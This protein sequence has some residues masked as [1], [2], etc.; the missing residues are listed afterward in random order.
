MDFNK[1]VLQGLAENPKYL[2]D[3]F[4]RESLKAIEN[5]YTKNEFFE[6]SK[7]V[8]NY[9]SQKLD[10][11]YFKDLDKLNDA[12]LAFDNGTFLVEN[13]K[14]KTKDWLNQYKNQIEEKRFST[15]T[16]LYF[17]F[18]GYNQFE[19]LRL[20]YDLIE[21]AKESLNEAKVKDKATLKPQPVQQPG[22]IQPTGK[23]PQK[24]RI[25]KQKNQVDLLNKIEP[26]KPDFSNI[27]EVY[28]NNLTLWLYQ[29]SH[30]RKD[31][32]ELDKDG[33]SSNIVNGWIN[34]LSKLEYSKKTQNGFE[35][36]EVDFIDSERDFLAEVDIKPLSIEQTKKFKYYNEFVSKQRAKATWTLQDYLKS[37]LK[38]GRFGFLFIKA[39]KNNDFNEVKKELDFYKKKY[40]YI[41]KNIDDLKKIEL[42][43]DFCDNLKKLSEKQTLTKYKEIIN[44]LINKIDAEYKEY[45]DFSVIPPKKVKIKKSEILHYINFDINFA[46]E[47]A[48]LQIKESDY[49]KFIIASN[50]ELFDHKTLSKF[51]LQANQTEYLNNE[52]KGTLKLVNKLINLENN[53]LKTIESET[54][55]KEIFN[56]INFGNFGF[57]NLSNNYKCFKIEG[58]IKKTV[59]LHTQENREYFAKH[60]RY[61][62]YST[63]D[64]AHKCNTI[65]QVITGFLN[66]ENQKQLNEIINESKKN[67]V[68]TSK[69]RGRK[70]AEVLDINDLIINID[71]SKK[72]IFLKMLKEKYIDSIP[73]EFVCLLEA[74]KDLNHIKF[75]PKK[76]TYKSF[77]NFFKK[78]YS[79]EQN[80]N[81]HL[82]SLRA[83]KKN[84]S[85]FDSIKK[86]IS[87]LK[88]SNSIF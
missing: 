26:I 83:N 45:K 79:S 30:T 18:K 19:N 37:Y 16:P 70:K 75:E 81:K 14:E 76:T 56:H 1:I 23:T 80:K 4:Y 39:F 68:K 85:R 73:K 84:D 60:N 64:F 41:F 48:E 44:D 66:I 25:L 35:L 55:E 34:D 59:N 32:S 38:T 65:L 10:E 3:Y 13:D 11:P 17:V 5:N 67:T 28:K 42:K 20:S 77:E 36:T 88:L 69:K 8:L 50:R 21:R 62:V 49:K 15:Q 86:E 71:Q 63:L 22:Q 33:F 6:K 47:L 31:N 57:C 52:L 40:D 78:D 29:N 61:K 72:D 51:L 7:D 53:E 43:N 2:T 27:D 24:E 9:I 12:L 58:L 87:D 46:L 54:K 82:D 74:L